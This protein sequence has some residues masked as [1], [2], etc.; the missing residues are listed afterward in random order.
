MGEGRSRHGPPVG[1]ASGGRKTREVWVRAVAKFE[2]SQLTHEAFCTQER[3]N[4]GTFRALLYRLRSE[5]MPGRPGFVELEARAPAG[6]GG[7][8][9]RVGN[10]EVEFA[11]LPDV[12]YLAQ[13]V[14]ALRSDVR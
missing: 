4:V 6:G 5:E 7:C 9:V 3:L 1:A 14:F 8:V 12:E 2:R 10:V 11:R 13:L